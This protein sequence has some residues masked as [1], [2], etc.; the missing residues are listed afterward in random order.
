VWAGPRRSGNLNKAILVT[1]AIRLQR[2]LLEL[3]SD[4]ATHSAPQELS[5][6]SSIDVFDKALRGCEGAENDH[7]LWCTTALLNDLISRDI[8]YAFRSLSE[9]Q[10]EAS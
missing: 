6:I 1:L 7:L 9:Q 4:L 5:V 8:H 2:T 10:I 3:R